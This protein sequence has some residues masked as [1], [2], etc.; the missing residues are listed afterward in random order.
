MNEQFSEL[1]PLELPNTHMNFNPFS[2]RLSLSPN[3]EQDRVEN[4][5]GADSQRPTRPCW[6]NTKV[7]KRGSQV[8]QAGGEEDDGAVVGVGVV[9]VVVVVAVAVIV[10]EVETVGGEMET[11]EGARWDDSE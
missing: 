7:H 3:S 5:T 11:D 1:A 2:L 6:K 4:N 8:P 10:V 9:V